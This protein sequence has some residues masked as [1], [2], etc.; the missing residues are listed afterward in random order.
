MEEKEKELKKIAFKECIR[1]LMPIRDA[2]DALGGKWRLQILIAVARGNN[3]FTTIQKALEDISPRILAKEL[4]T[5]EEH[6]LLDRI[7]SST[8]PVT[9]SYEWTAHTKS[10]EDLLHTLSDWGTKHREF[11]FKKKIKPLCDRE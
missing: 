9:V 1:S 10:V 5:L 11:L 2:I 8:Y 3:R 6:K 7:V 4:K